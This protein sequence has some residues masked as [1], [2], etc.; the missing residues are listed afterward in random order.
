MSA[1]ISIGSK[2][3]VDA[4]SPNTKARIITRAIPMPFIPDLDNPSKNI[5]K[6][7]AIHCSVDRLKD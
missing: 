2:M 3:P 7:I 6:Q 5:A 1:Q 4:F